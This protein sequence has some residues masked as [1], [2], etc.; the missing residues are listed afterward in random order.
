MPTV[1][2][3][4]SSGGLFS[5]GVIS[6]SRW[7]KDQPYVVKW[8]TKGKEWTTE[9]AIKQHLSKAI[10]SGV[11]VTGWEILQV[12]YT[13]TKPLDEWIDAKMLMTILKK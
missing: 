13:P 12:T 11:S 3:I 10:A 9:R 8:S 6:K 7:V 1:Y 2:K 5:H 4:R